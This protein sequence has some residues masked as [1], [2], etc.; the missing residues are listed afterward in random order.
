MRSE[1]AR[2]ASVRV[3]EDPQDPQGS[4]GTDTEG[5]GGDSVVLLGSG[6]PCRLL[7]NQNRGQ[8]G[9]LA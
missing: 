4:G 5:K 6:S 2:C 1:N 9:V 7:D 3:V 8:S